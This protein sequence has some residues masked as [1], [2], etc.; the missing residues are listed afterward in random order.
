MPVPA[1]AGGDVDRPR[2]QWG[3]RRQS[4]PA[5]SRMTSTKSSTAGVGLPL[6]RCKR[7]MDRPGSGNVRSRGIICPVRISSSNS[8]IERKEIWLELSS[9]RSEEH[10]SE[11]QS[12]MRNSYAVFC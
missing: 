2:A 8:D 4:S 7:Q 11:L 3:Q 1:E 5:T 12:L 6:R 9:N 10:T